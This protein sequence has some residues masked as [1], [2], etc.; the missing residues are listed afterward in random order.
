MRR[1]KFEQYIFMMILRLRQYVQWMQNRKYFLFT[2]GI[3]F[4]T[5]SLFLSLLINL[6]FCYFL[7]FNKKKNSLLENNIILNQKKYYFQ[8][9]RKS[10]SHTYFIMNNQPIKKIRIV[11][12]NKCL[13]NTSSILGNL[14]ITYVI[15]FLDSKLWIMIDSFIYVGLDLDEYKKVNFFNEL[16]FYNHYIND[17]Y[18]FYEVSLNDKSWKNFVVNSRSVN[19][20]KDSEVLFFKN[21]YINYFLFNVVIVTKSVVIFVSSNV[22][23]VCDN[24]LDFDVYKK[25]GFKESFELFLRS[26]NAKFYFFS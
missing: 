18:N 22:L 17:Y 1:K 13:I 7:K 24:T 21:I 23:Y 19:K 6:K 11:L 15:H 10:K 12:Y 4:L 9:K 2:V 26:H 3:L 16:E 5:L 8:D 25:R 20:I 14:D